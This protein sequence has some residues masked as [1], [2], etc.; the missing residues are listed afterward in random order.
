MRVPLREIFDFKKE[1]SPVVLLL[2]SFFFLTI[3][4]FQ[5]VK[6]L[7]KGLFLE[8]YG[9]DMELYSKLANILIAGLGAMFFTYL[10]NRLPRQKILYIFCLFFVVSF[11]LVGFFSNNPSAG[12]I[13]GF[14]FLGDLESTLMVAAF[15]AYL[16]DISTTDQ[17]KRLFGVIGG[18]GV[19][20]G[21]VG[22]TFS[23]TLLQTIGTQGLMVLA[24]VLMIIILAIVFLTERLVRRQSSFEDLKGDTADRALRSQEPFTLSSAFEG[25]RLVARSKYLL[26][27][28]G[29]MGFYEMA[30]QVMDYQFATVAEPLTGVVLTQQ[31]IAD[32]NFFANVL[33][34][35]VQ[36]F[37]VSFIVKKFGVAPALLILPLA[38]IFSSLAFCVVSTLYV[39]SMMKISDNGLNYSIQ[40]TARETL[41]VIA[42]SEEKYKVRAFT[43]MFVQRL[44]KG[45]GILGVLSLIFLNLSVRYLSV[46]TVVVAIFMIFCSVY[47]GRIFDRKSDLS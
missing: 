47:A 3:A 15:F 17:A 29:I 11:L 46:I 35:F 43:N 34:V 21:W 31:F 14:Y 28:T 5:I 41:Y 44:A 45:V 24:A 33:A 18:G 16:T 8:Y 37:L 10:Y 12:L 38:I 40:Q 36:F 32:V 2:F 4:I 25:A 9:A 1:E 27:I 6:P 39:A 26:A 20:G 23:T 13:W 30:S 22:A 7:K 19:L 42:T